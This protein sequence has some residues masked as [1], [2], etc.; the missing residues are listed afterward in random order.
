MHNVIVWDR[1]GE[2]VQVVS[3]IDVGF[4]HRLE[5]FGCPFAS[6]MDD[7]ISS[8]KMNYVPTGSNMDEPITS[9]RFFGSDDR[10]FVY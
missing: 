3:H 7:R 6:N 9:R 8:I 4:C 5:E 10:H 2:L 1:T